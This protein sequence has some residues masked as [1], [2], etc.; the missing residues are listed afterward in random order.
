MPTKTP[1]PSDPVLQDKTPV[2]IGPGDMTVAVQ[3]F[4]W[5]R[6][7]LPTNGIYNS[8]EVDIPPQPTWKFNPSYPFSARRV[9]AALYV[10]SV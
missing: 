1:K 3:T 7:E 4:E 5:K 6:I 8:M 9:L 2:D 10:C